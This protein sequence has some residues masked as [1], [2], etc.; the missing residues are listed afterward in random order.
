M[1]GERRLV[2]VRHA[3]SGYPHG[4]PDHDRPL[5][6]K[7]RRNAQA[8]GRWFVTEGPR[9]SLALCSDATR[10]R[11]TWEIIRAELVGAGVDAPARFEPRL[12]GASPDEVVEMARELPADVASVVVVGHEPT[13]SGVTHDLAGPGSDAGALAAVALKFPT[14]AIAVLHF[15]GEWCD[16]APG[17]A[18]GSEHQLVLADDGDPRLGDGEA[19][20]AVLV[21]IHPDPRTLRNLHVLVEDRAADDGVTADVDVVHQHAVAHR[22]PRVHAHVR[23][24]H[25][26][27]DQRP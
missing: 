14:S 8:V 11:H 12:Y 1:V 2:L 27:L 15:S 19:A 23:R 5:V 21:R 17:A 22:G 26:I 20:G 3:K 7:G 18:R 13:M 25:R 4:V 6:G 24:E 9:V 10:A 16:L